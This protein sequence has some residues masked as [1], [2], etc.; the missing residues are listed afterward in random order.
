MSSHHQ[1][2][3]K[4]RKFIAESSNLKRTAVVS[5]PQIDYAINTSCN[6]MIIIK[7]LMLNK[8]DCSY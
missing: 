3:K 4:G 5:P 2:K 8:L 6:V 7:I 1:I